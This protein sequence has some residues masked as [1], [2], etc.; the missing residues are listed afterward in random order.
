[1]IPGLRL[2]LVFSRLVIHSDDIRDRDESSATFS[3]ST[4]TILY[5][6]RMLNNVIYSSVRHSLEKFIR[7]NWA[8]KNIRVWA[9]LLILKLALRT[10][11][12]HSPSK[13]YRLT[14]LDPDETR[15]I[16][17]EDGQ[18][19]DE[20]VF[21][22][23]CFSGFRS[24]APQH[25]FT[26]VKF[27]LD[28]SDRNFATFFGPNDTSVAEEF[29][30]EKSKWLPTPKV[31]EW[32]PPYN[33]RL[34]QHACIGIYSR[35]PYVVQLIHQHVDFLRLLG[36][37]IGLGIFWK[38]RMLCVNVLVYYG[39]GMLIG[40]VCSMIVLVFIL[41]R[42]I[43]RKSLAMTVMV[44][45][46]SIALYLLNLAR[47]N[48]VSLVSAYSV[49]FGGYCAACALLS[50]FLMYR[51]QPM[52][53]P[54]SIDILEWLLQF[55]GAVLIFAC[56]EV[57]E[58]TFLTICLLIGCRY[59]PQKLCDAFAER[60]QGFRYRFAFFRPAPRYLT[61]QEYIEQGY[62]E[63]RRELDELRKF[64]SSPQCNAWKTVNR[65]KDPKRFAEFIDGGHHIKDDEILAYDTFESKTPMSD[66]DEDEEN[67]ETELT[68][69]TTSRTS[70]T[71][72]MSATPI[73]SRFGASS[74]RHSIHPV[75]RG[76]L[77]SSRETGLSESD[78]DSSFDQ[79]VTNGNSNRYYEAFTR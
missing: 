6:E 62:I 73:R 47:D 78:N 58:F 14:Y 44:G 39:S 51:Y 74:S 67:L 71:G 66:D 19:A 53:H 17:R 68:A 36:F 16:L 29:D 37:L 75:S 41:G 38:A 22:V 26:S 77:K 11:D 23:F 76:V 13:K 34:Y 60:L 49:M 50:F 28:T 10:G 56:S 5:L 35:R 42:K 61:E 32:G 55:V 59:I 70:S 9:I 40:I 25:I 43:P 18:R 30:A 4:L 52:R 64:C 24:V 8:M 79:N 27:R 15:Q 12:T 63:T 31:F 21:E 7:R 65:L 2:V 46:W 54:R 45:G 72:A 69:P 57:K 3:S 20:Q 48:F 33:M 1:M